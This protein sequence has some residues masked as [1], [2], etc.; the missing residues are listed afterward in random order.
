MKVSNESGKL[1]ISD[2]TTSGGTTVYELIT[3][4]ETIAGLEPTTPQISELTDVSIGN[5]LDVSGIDVSQNI[6]VGKLLHLGSSDS[7]DISGSLRY[8]D[9]SKVEVWYEN[10]WN[11]LGGGGI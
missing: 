9:I 3:K 10:Q 1:K 8:T 2:N 11:E 5:K 6:T 7:S 4:V